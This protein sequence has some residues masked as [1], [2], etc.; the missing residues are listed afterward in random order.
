MLLELLEL[1]DFLLLE[2]L[3]LLSD[4]LLESDLSMSFFKL[5]FLVS[6]VSLIF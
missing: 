3:D 1:L 4:S 6:D 2:L 5:P